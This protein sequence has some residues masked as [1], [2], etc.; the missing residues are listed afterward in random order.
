MKIIKLAATFFLAL[1][2]IITTAQTDVKIVKKDFKVDKEGFR[3]AW[4]NISEGDE[5]YLLGGG[6]YPEALVKYLAALRYNSANAALNYKIGVSCLYGDKPDQ[7]LEYFL[8]A[9]DADPDIAPDI[10]LLTGLA[11][12]SKGD[13][14][15]AIDCFNIYSDMNIG[16][17]KMDSRVNRYIRECTIAISM[18]GKG[19][20]AEIL[21]M[22][23][24][25]NTESDDYAPVVVSDGSLIYFTSRRAVQQK[26]ERNKADMKFDESVFLSTG[27][28]GTWSPSGIAGK[29]IATELNEGVLYVNN[30]NTLMYLYIGWSGNGDIYVSEFNKGK[31]S[32]P[33]P[34]GG[35]INSQARETSFAVTASTDERFFTSD[36]KKDGMGGRDIWYTR[37]IKK[38]KWTK[39]VN[40]GPMVNS[41]GNEESVWVSPTGDTLWFSSNG[42]DGM[43]GYDVYVTYRSSDGE[44]SYPENVGIPVNSQWDDYFYRPLKGTMERAYLTS[45]RPG[46]MGGFDMY[47]VRYP[48][49]DT[50]SVIPPVIEGMVTDTVVVPVTLPTVITSPDTT[51]QII[52]DT[53][54]VII[55][56]TIPVFNK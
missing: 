18:A 4:K 20:E 30:E 53:T 55:P 27:N 29:N 31:W 54:I 41:V 47:E 48:A 14:G 39:P 51:M 17:K 38:E 35:N 25:I 12:Q 5:S 56:D 22:G 16:S 8:A 40:L 19:K 23:V 52:P 7:A 37:R 32:V 1:N 43:G 3:E 24:S 21:N 10:M 49:V 13:Y 33:V 11:Y 50:I 2:F 26:G 6:L 45:N 44:W 46:G 42:L 34:V 28:K 9:R 36:R 15:M